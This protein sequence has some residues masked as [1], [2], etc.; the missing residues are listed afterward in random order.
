MLLDPLYVCC[1]AGTAPFYLFS[2]RIVKVTDLLLREL[3][4]VYV[5]NDG[6][7]AWKMHGGKRLRTGERKMEG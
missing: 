7:S 1:V 4:E 3:N 5:R 2:D 6:T